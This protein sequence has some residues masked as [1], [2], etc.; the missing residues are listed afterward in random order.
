MNYQG[1]SFSDSIEKVIKNASKFALRFGSNLVGSEHILYGLV[2]VRD[3]L[4]SKFLA[5]VGVT[6]PALFEFF[7]ENAPEDNLFGMEIG[8]AHV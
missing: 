3:C 2:S 5:E 7:E 1:G 8:R 4:A 6:E